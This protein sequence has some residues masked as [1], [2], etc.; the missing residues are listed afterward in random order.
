MSLLNILLGTQV[1]AKVARA[2]EEVYDRADEHLRS[3][4][5][6]R[7]QMRNQLSEALKQVVE[8]RR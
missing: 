1:K 5:A 7:E 6:S 8:D 3:L 2:R 4:E